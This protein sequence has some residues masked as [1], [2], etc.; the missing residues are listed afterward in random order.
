M[1]PTMTL[2]VF[3]QFE[4]R[5]EPEVDEW[6]RR[7]V[8]RTVVDRQSAL[9]SDIG[10]ISIVIHSLTWRVKLLGQDGHRKGC[11][12]SEVSIAEFDS[13]AESSMLNYPGCI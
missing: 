1:Y 6:K 3:L 13:G 4:I 10:Q 8:H 2:Q 9:A 12:T 5:E 7:I 11:L